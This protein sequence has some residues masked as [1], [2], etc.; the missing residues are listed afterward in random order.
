MIEQVLDRDNLRAAWENVQA[1][2]GAPGSDAVTLRRWGRNWEANL[3][4]LAQQVR[5]NTYH[6]NRPRRFKV[7]KKDGT[8][9]EL[10][11]LTVTDRVL[12]RAVLNVIDDRFE[13]R[14]LNC[15]FG[16]R[17]GR[18]VAHAITSVVRQRE[19]GHVWV[20]DADI[21]DCFDSLDHGVIL[22]LLE[23]VVDDAL[24]LNLFKLWLKAGQPPPRPS[25]VADK[26]RD[27]G[28][29]GVPQGAVISP[30]L[31]NVVLHEM[32]AALRAAEWLEVRYADDFIV[33]TDSEEQAAWARV[34]VEEALLN[35]RLKLNAH[36][37]RLTSFAQGFRFL[38]VD[39]K[40]DTYAYV[41]QQKQ[42]K[43]KGPTTRLLYRYLP[44]FY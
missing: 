10:S 2:R 22:H 7:L 31:C 5:S 44:Q 41:C 15:S 27:R 8:F 30:L 43:V 17:P 40:D 29:C 28:R 19:R 6:P 36:K 35:L 42:V 24:T 23:P 9:R 4:R 39:F 25:P 33:L 3:D 21:E 26:R 20:L 16:Y 37:T 18:S 1:N 11:I 12:Q 14:F 13:R 38:G 32:D 34:D